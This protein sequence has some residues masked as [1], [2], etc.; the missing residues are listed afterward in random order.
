M[1]NNPG[2]DVMGRYRK[3]FA[4]RGIRAIEPANPDP[5]SIV[6]QSLVSAQV[7]AKH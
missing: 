3:S 5:G 7:T 1:P 6:Q 4:K 2:V